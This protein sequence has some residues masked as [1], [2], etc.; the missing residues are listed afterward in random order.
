MAIEMTG[1]SK[2]YG[3]VK[4][5]EGV[6]FTVEPGEIVGLVGDNGA[7]KSTLIKCL[8]GVLQPDEGEIVVD[9]QRRQFRTPNEARAA[10]IETLYQDLALSDG[11]NVAMNV[12]LGREVTT[13]GGWLKFREMHEHA[14]RI[15]NRFSIREVETTT[16]VKNISGGQRQV[17][18]L[19]RTLGF[20]S[21]YVILDE[22][23]SALS[24]AAA[25]EVIEV[26]R[27]LREEGFGV[28]MITHNVPHAFETTDRIVVMHLGEIAGERVTREATHQEIVSLVMGAQR[29][30]DESP[31]PADR[32]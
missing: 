9:G 17:V 18:A 13:R 10:G 3:A 29:I 23:T 7:G 27:N 26:V 12:F 21:R 22:P 30:A 14:S 11:L 4:A 32:S 5:I 6:D 15:I 28:V 20:G 31:P 19:A 2:S 25:D 1:I 24:P 16:Y 8:S